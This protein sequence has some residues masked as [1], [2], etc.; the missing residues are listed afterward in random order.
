MSAQS[1]VLPVMAEQSIEELQKRYQRLDK[2][3]TE[4]EIHL[5][6]ASTRLSDLQQEAREKYGT[7]DLA[8]LR[9]KLAAMKSENDQKR[10]KYQADLD[11]IESD[12]E[13]VERSFAAV[14]GEASAAGGRS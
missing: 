12:L 11:R 1:R 4:A 13:A 14:A 3:K 10:Q 9:K 7:D 5:N 6:H 8:E 2:R